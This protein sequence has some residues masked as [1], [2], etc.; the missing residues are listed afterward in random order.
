MEKLIA[1]LW[2]RENEPLEELNE[3]AR[4][5]LVESLGAAGA[6]GIRVNIQDAT[7]AAGAA[8]V[9]RFSEPPPA[10]LVQFWLPSGNAIFR[11]EVDAALSANSGKFALY[12]VAESTIIP[13]PEDARGAPGERNAGWSQ[14]ALIPLPDRLTREQFMD[15]W[16]DS[17]TRIAIDTQSNFEYV[18]NTVLRCLTPGSPRYAAIVEE[19]F[20]LEALSDPFV[21]FDAVGDEAKFNENLKIM[22]DSCDRFIDRGVVDVLPTSQFDYA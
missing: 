2:P 22:M 7:V 8:L 15:V 11:G 6:T 17:H 19:C 12:L 18:Q 1:A 5:S 10:A 3:R 16:H 14:M 13:Q 20:P 21:F 4:G 9:Q